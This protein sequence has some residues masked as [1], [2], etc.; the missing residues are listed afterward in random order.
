MC[1]SDGNLVYTRLLPLCP[2]ATR[3]LRM[4][5]RKFI[6]T[7]TSRSPHSAPFLQISSRARYV[8]AHFYCNR[9]AF[10]QA[11]S[12]R[13]PALINTHLHGFMSDTNEENFSAI[14]ENKVLPISRT[15]T[16]GL[17]PPISEGTHFSIF[18]ECSIIFRLAD[19]SFSP[20]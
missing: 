8:C 15:P 5:R 18:A 12:G 14:A 20:A 16:P 17:P 7:R 6:L 3:V 9:R 1:G 19:C 10:S 11:T 13:R 4:P 2:P